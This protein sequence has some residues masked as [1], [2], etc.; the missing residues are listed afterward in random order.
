MIDSGAVPVVPPDARSSGKRPRA[1]SS[2]AR[3]ASTRVQLPELEAS[4]ESD[5]YFVEAD[6]PDDALRR[7]LTVVV[8][9]RIPKRFG[10]DPVRDVQV[11]SPDA[12]R[13][14]SARAR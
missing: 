10:L 11:L 6:E 2:S 3:T 8:A 13:D 5:F 12:P 4:A 14:G 1:G 9:E 7:L